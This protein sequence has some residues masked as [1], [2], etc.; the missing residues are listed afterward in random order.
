MTGTVDPVG[1]GHRH[2]HRHGHGGVGTVDPDGSNNS[3]TDIDNLTPEVDLVIDKDDSVVT[4][5]P[6]STVTYTITVSN[7][8]G[9]SD[10]VG[11]AVVDSFP[12]ELTSTSWT[13]AR[14]HRA[15]RAAPGSG[16]G[17]INT[18][19]DLPVGATATFTATGT[20]VSTATGASDQHGDRLGARW[21]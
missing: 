18:T 10:V 19:V 4:A 1:N 17:D 7:P 13:C 5:V 20:V 14:V 11:A 3:A 21:A 6:G 12:A 9:P 15:V 8:T 16:S 2:E